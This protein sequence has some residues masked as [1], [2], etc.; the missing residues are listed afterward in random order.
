MGRKTSARRHRS[1]HAADRTRHTQADPPP[2][3]DDVPGGRL[4]P[5]QDPKPKRPVRTIRV[6]SLFG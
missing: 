2:R 4:P 3:A 1:Q 6:R 5:H